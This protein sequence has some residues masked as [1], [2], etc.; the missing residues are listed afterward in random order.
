MRAW[1]CT[2]SKV[3]TRTPSD[4]VSNYDGQTTEPV[5]LPARFPNLL[6][7]GQTGIAVGMATNIPPH[8]LREIIDA[9]VHVVDNPDCSID[10][11]M[12]YVKGPDFPTYG[13]IV[14]RRGI[15]D[16]YRTGRGSIKLRA[17]TEVV[18]TKTGYQIVA[19]Q[20]PY[21]VSLQRTAEKIA[22]LVKE[23]RVDG[24]RNVRD[25]SDKNGP[26]LIV[27]L[28]RDAVPT[29]VLNN[30]YKHTQL[31]DSFGVNMVA[32]V[33]GVPRTLNIRDVLSHYVEHQ[34]EV[35][36][37]RTRYRLRKAQDRAHIVEGLLIALDRID[38]VI[39]IIRASA[40]AEEAR[41][42]L[43]E[44]IGVSEIQ[45][46]HILDMPL[47]RLTSLETSKLQHELDELHRTI[48]ELESILA[49]PAKLA[50]CDQGRT[51]S[52]TR[53]IR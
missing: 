42:A 39:A 14:G 30:L 44:Q 36:E 16:A 11:V 51:R 17:E 53:Q 49:D 35:V 21:Q 40:D 18:E 10:D 7:N 22:Q 26:R 1:R 52:G 5:V 19:T 24:I 25:E 31:Q 50:R 15:E 38:E 3:S 12:Q 28:K 4:F 46:Q 2:Y 34:V 9:T 6:V 47:R 32:L 8:N 29:V 45:A 23:G 13:L 43:M 37:R 20:L 48:T 33:D 27:E 41:H